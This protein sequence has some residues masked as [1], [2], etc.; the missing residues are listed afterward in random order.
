MEIFRYICSDQNF[1]NLYSD[2]TAS[3]QIIHQGEIISV[4]KA[5]RTVTVRVSN[6]D[7]CGGCP[8]ATLCGISGKDSG[9]LITIKIRGTGV[10]T[11]GDKVEV[12]GTESMH[13]KAIML[14]TVI[15]SITMIAIMTLIY[16]LTFNQLYAAIGGVGSMFFFFAIIYL[17]RNKIAHEF[18]FTIKH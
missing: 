10:Y 13:R 17:F 3:E 18:N 4:D 6:D 12:I 14:A 7:E 11:K 8:A 2:T 9:Q 15:P 16:L 5:Q 1:H